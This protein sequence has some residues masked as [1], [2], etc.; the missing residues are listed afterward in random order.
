MAGVDKMVFVVSTQ[1][2]DGAPLYGVC[3]YW[4]EP[5]YL[6]YADEDVATEDGRES[7]GMREVELLKSRKC[8]CLLSRYGVMH[9]L[10]FIGAYLHAFIGAD[11]HT[12]IHSV[13]LSPSL[14]L[15]HSLTLT[16]KHSNTHTR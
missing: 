7:R 15:T 4:D 16:H 1:E 8:F 11:L 5:C 9:V 14:P 10:A 2:N 13:C 3:L 6:I 12:W